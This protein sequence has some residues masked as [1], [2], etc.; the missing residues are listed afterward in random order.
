[1]I[2]ITGDRHGEYDG[3]SDDKLPGQ[4]S[5]GENDTVIITGD[6]GYVMRGERN[7]LPEKNNLDELAK[8]RYTICF[9]DGNHESFDSLVN[10]PEEIR[11][12][13]PVRRIRKNIFWLR[14]K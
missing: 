6:F 2:H 7:S 8:K 11:F 9:C 1:M 14:R 12:G 10:Y 5:W 4:S 13:A 3:F